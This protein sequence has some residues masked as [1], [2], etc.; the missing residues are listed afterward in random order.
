MGNDYSIYPLN[1]PVLANDFGTLKRKTT[2]L[3][4]LFTAL[5]LRPDLSAQSPARGNAP[6][7]YQ[8][9]KT[10]KKITIDGHWDKAEWQQV[11]SLVIEQNMGKAPKFKPHTEV[12]MTYDTANIYVIFQVHDRY[13]KSQVRNYNG[14][15][16]GD[17]CVE[18]FFAPDPALPNQ[19][20]NLEVNAG[21]TPLLFYVTTPWTWF[22]KLDSTDISQI[23]IAHSL[24]SILDTEITDPVTWTIEYRVPFTILKKFSRIAKPQPGA[25]WR[26]NFYKTASQTSNPHWIT[27]SYVN[28]PQPNFHL[29]QFFGNLI[30]N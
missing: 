23:E 2:S 5:F 1:K 29:P 24:P 20:F 19:Y 26:A 10:P 6:S 22:N 16:S 9:S 17:A 8:V 14:N 15:V 28:N 18:F 30:F 7:T 12:K 13:V 25:I 27:W 3:F 4:L 11:H 21:G